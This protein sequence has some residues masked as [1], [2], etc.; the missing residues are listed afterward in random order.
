MFLVPWATVTGRDRHGLDF[1]Q[2]CLSLPH[3]EATT[4]ARA[5]GAAWFA[6]AGL[7]IAVAGLSWVGP[8]G[9]AARMALPWTVLA[10]TAIAGGA[11]LALR[12]AEFADVRWG[13]AVT[14][15]G[16]VV[17]LVGTLLRSNE[18]AGQGR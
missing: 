14:A 18:E 8:P 9:R 17:A 13:P 6:L 1:A 16:T 5:I 3:I 2:V 11:W 7:W 4:G 15:A 12:N 10:M